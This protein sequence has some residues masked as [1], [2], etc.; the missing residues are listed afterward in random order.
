MALFDTSSKRSDYRMGLKMRE[1]L[2][3]RISRPER[4]LL[5]YPGG[6]SCPS[7]AESS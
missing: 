6:L 1:W 5:P 3:I 4:F 2:R 7:L